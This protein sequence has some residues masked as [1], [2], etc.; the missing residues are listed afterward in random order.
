MTDTNPN[1][2]I[3]PS[4]IK[5][6]TKYKWFAFVCDGEVA[7]LSAIPVHAEHQLAVMQSNPIVV[8]IEPDEAK[9]GDLY[10]NGQFVQP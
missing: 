9:M 10:V 7:S 5:D 4:D 1:Q 8:P 6:T 2:G 3:V